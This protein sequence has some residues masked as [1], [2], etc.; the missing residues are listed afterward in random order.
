M[1]EF[2]HHIPP[3]IIGVGA[4]LAACLPRIGVYQPG[5]IQT[6]RSIADH[7]RRRH[8]FNGGR[9]NGNH[10][11]RNRKRSVFLT[12]PAFADFA[13][14]FIGCV[15]L[16]GLFYHF[17]LPEPSNISASMPVLMRL[18]LENNLNRSAIG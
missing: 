10:G 5:G 3:A 7:V 9:A 16:L 14:L 8:G 18:A 17:F 2:I 12:N 1:T 13:E 4:G 11:H 6:R 15:V